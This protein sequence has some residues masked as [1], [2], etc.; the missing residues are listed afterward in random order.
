MMRRTTINLGQFTSRLGAA[1]LDLAP[2]AN[3]TMHIRRLSAPPPEMLAPLTSFLLAHAPRH[4]STT[5]SSTRQS[6]KRSRYLKLALEVCRSERPIVCY[7][8]I[9]GCLGVE[10]RLRPRNGISMR[11]KKVWG[12]FKIQNVLYFLDLMLDAFFVISV[13]V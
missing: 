3:S 9:Y 10:G 11:K 2:L 1:F 7:A 4:R 8:R 12:P 13:A 6:R 5:S